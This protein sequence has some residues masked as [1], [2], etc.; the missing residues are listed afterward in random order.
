MEEALQ[1][2]AS[3]LGVAHNRRHSLWRLIRLEFQP[4][5]KAQAFRLHCFR[6]HWTFTFEPGLYEYTCLVDFGFHH[7]PVPGNLGKQ[8]EGQREPEIGKRWRGAVVAAGALCLV[9]VNREAPC[10]S[11]FAHPFQRLGVRL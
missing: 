11:L 2:I 4:G 7:F 10:V 9:A 3:V 1:D 8:S 6:Q 5:L